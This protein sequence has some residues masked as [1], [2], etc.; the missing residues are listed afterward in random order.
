MRRLN[1]LLFRILSLTRIVD[2]A[3]YKRKYLDVARSGLDTSYHYFRYG[4]FEGRHPN[5]SF[6]KF[7][8]WRWDASTSLVVRFFLNEDFYLRTYQDVQKE[9]ISAAEHYT[10]KGRKER[11]KPN[12][13]AQSLE[14]LLFFVRLELKRRAGTGMPSEAE[15]E[16]Y[17]YIVFETAR[18]GVFSKWK[19]KAISRQLNAK[20]ID[21]RILLGRY[22][23]MMHTELARTGHSL[24]PIEPAYPM[25]FQEPEVIGSSAERPLRT[26]QVPEKWIATVKN[27]TVI[28]GF[29][30]LADNKLVIYEPAANP[31]KGFVAGIWQHIASLNKKSEILL[32]FRYRKEASLPAAILLSG[33]CSPNYYHWLVEYLG[34]SYILSGQQQ[35]KKIPLIVDDGMFPQEFESLQALLPDWPLYRLDNSTLLKV[36]KLHVPSSCTNLADNLLDPMWK[37]SA[38]CFRTLAHMQSGVFEQFNIDSGGRGSR[39]IFLAR[40]SGRNIVNTAEV[41]AILVSFGYEIVDTGTLSFEQQ[42]RL[43]AEARIIVGAMG[44]AN[45]NLIF[46]R[47]GTHVLALASPYTQ[48]FC[49][50][51]N[52]ALF[53]GCSYRILVGKHQ[54][55]QPGDEHTVSDPSLFLDSYAIDPNEL[56]A[57]LAHIELQATTASAAKQ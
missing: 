32:W 3:Y 52:M 47:P 49:S 18:H 19:A 28:G 33:R 35:L 39:K 6:E 9:G 50:Q 24:K 13:A 31:H 22:G 55:F 25:S 8:I 29:Q 16:N 15:L 1:L 10:K 40:R 7:S 21:G 46:C 38:I 36:K 26:V 48:L 23:T 2:D 17:K 34:K 37:S 11:R 51:S 4:F 41:E 12:Q 30:I 14:D 43:F 20:N 54:L 57:A 27:A 53:A 5:L 44:A 56:A 45:T 42:V